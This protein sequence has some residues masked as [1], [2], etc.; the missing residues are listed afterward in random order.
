MKYYNDVKG[1]NSRLDELQAAFLRVKLCHLDEWNTRRSKI[2]SAYLNFLADLHDLTLPHVPDWASP[3]WH[4]FPIRHSKRDDLQKYLKNKG[5]D[6]LIHYPVP[7]HLAGAYADLS[8]PKGAFP[9][10]ETIASS[11]L[12]LPMG[13]HLS[14]EDVEYVANTIREFVYQA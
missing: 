14:L 3:I 2:A 12:S 11:E 1:Y 5:V 13:P 10:A 7:P 8:L 6:T 4:I 9:I